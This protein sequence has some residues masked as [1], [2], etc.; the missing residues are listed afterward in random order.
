MKMHWFPIALFGALVYG[1]F[2]TLFTLV[3]KEI[4]EDKNAQI[5]Y[6]LL[7]VLFSL[8]VNM[9]MLAYIHRKSP[10]STKNVFK[11]TNWWLFSLLIFINLIYN[12]LHSLI[13]NSGG[14]V[15]QETTYALSILPVL[16]GSW[17]F[18]NERLSFYQWMGVALAASGAFLMDYK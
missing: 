3:P 1:T 4:K 10:I 8:P 12:P 6:A 17:Y 7:I 14:S 9:L 13:I 5:G 2:S 15:A 18:L 11:Y 16:F